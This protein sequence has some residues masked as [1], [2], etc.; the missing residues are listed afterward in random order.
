MFY[1]YLKFFR[2]WGHKETPQFISYSNAGTLKG[3]VF[4]GSGED[5][6]KLTKKNNDCV[7][8]QPFSSFNGDLAMCQVIFAVQVN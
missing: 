3:L 5:C 1:T 4:G 7:T 8:M 2:I 6:N